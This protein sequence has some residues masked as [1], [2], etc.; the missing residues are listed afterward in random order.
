MHI[1]YQ[2]V[3]FCW[4]LLVGTLPYSFLYPCFAYS[5]AMCHFNETIASTYLVWLLKSIL[6]LQV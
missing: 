5:I 4:S 6:L 3:Q 2:H 1:L